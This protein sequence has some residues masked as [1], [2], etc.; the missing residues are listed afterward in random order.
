[1]LS[2]ADLQSAPNY[3]KSLPASSPAC[4]FVLQL[5]SPVQWET[6]LQTLLSKGRTLHALDA[7][8]PVELST[9]PYPCRFLLFCSL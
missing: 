3:Y 7:N 9:N 2:Y 1:L 6:S 4:C 8:L 5:T